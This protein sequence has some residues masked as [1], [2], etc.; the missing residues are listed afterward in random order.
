MKTLCFITILTLCS[1]CALVGE[2][3][4]GAAAGVSEQ[5]GPQH[6]VAILTIEG[7]G[8]I[9][10]SGDV[11]SNCRY[12]DKVIVDSWSN[13]FSNNARNDVNNKI[14]NKASRMNANVFANVDCLNFTWLKRE[15]YSWEADAYYCAG[16]EN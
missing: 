4:I 5:R 12:I 9:Y 11:S 6:G 15:V 1:S 13:E 14:R 7:A 16:E 2:F 8:I 3:F 10:E